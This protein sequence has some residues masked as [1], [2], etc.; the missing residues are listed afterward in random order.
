M[1][2]LTEEKYLTANGAS[3]FDLGESALHKNR[4]N[5]SDKIW[6]Q[7]VNTQAEKDRVLI[8][9]RQQLREEYHAQVEAGVIRPPTRIERLTAIAAGDPD[10]EA[11]QAAKRLLAKLT[12]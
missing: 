8:T 12:A 6:S 7:I 4:G 3:K 2:I 11:T 5:H 10:L 1:Q 9:R